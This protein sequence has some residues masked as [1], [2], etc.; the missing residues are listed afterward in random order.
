VRSCVPTVTDGL[1]PP[2]TITKNT[3]RDQAKHRM[4]APESSFKGGAIFFKPVCDKV[5]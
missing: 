3:T 4:A 5:H 2:F 1:F